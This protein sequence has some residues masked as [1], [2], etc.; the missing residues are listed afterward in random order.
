MKISKKRIKEIIEEELDLAKDSEL[1]EGF[2]YRGK[3][4]Y[5]PWEEE[6]SFD[7]R[8]SVAR[9]MLDTAIDPMGAAVADITGF[10]YSPTGIVADYLSTAGKFYVDAYLEKTRAALNAANTR[11]LSS[12]PNSR[13][14]VDKQLYYFVF[15]GTHMTDRYD[16]TLRSRQLD[17]SD[18]FDAIDLFYG[19]NKSEAFQKQVSS[20]ETALD[21]NRDAHPDFKGS[22]NWG[23]NIGST[24]LP[25]QYYWLAGKFRQYGIR[26]GDDP[27][28]M[29]ILSE[30]DPVA[31]KRRELEAQALSKNKDVE[32][33][34]P[35]SSEREAQPSNVSQDS[36]KDDSKYSEEEVEF[37]FQESSL[38]TLRLIEQASEVE[39]AASSVA[40]KASQTASQV[41][42]AIARIGGAAKAGYDFIQDR[43]EDVEEFASDP[44]TANIALVAQAGEDWMSPFSGQKRYAQIEADKIK[45]AMESSNG[46]PTWDV[47]YALRDDDSLQNEL[48]RLAAQLQGTGWT[49]LFLGPMLSTVFTLDRRDQK[50]YCLYSFKTTDPRWVETVPNV[51]GKVMTFSYTN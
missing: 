19:S 17:T 34:L 46:I 2:S 32:A 38:R 45:M 11:V 14:N 23:P 8:K 42:S 15:A 47:Y 18:I 51:S 36:S 37:T 28:I 7:P 26:S 30:I 20:R 12:P 33:E 3:K 10:E 44:E 6:A 40:S 13:Y 27:K 24:S 48:E 39:Q 50:Q 4:Y 29:F 25:P 35:G 41:S 1:L 16:K 49:T 31:R 21:F 5:W 9:A 43:A 22:I